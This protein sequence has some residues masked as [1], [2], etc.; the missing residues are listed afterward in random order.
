MT[1]MTVS[2]MD[3]WWLWLLPYCFF[4]LRGNGQIKDVYGGLND[5]SHNSKNC[6]FWH[7]HV[8]FPPQT[9]VDDPVFNQT[10]GNPAFVWDYFQ[11]R[12]N[13]NLVLK[14]VFVAAGRI[15][16]K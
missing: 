11:R 3:V 6:S 7:A 14:G 16:L 4:R 5:P 13:P 9:E 12:I 1:P 8:G 2:G 10:G 15:K